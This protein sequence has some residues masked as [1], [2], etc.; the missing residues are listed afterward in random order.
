MMTYTAPDGHIIESLPYPLEVIYS[1]D[2]S[3]ENY[4]DG[5]YKSDEIK[6]STSQIGIQGIHITRAVDYDKMEIT[7]V[8]F[9]EQELIDYINNNKLYS[10]NLDNNKLNN[11]LA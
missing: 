1:S 5:I 6:G 4:S 2:C 10:D 11:N 8:E 9:S 3:P 7:L